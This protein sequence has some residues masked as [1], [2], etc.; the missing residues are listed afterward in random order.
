ME[1]TTTRQSRAEKPLERNR[2][3][4][5]GTAPLATM[6][7]HGPD[8]GRHRIAYAIAVA[9]QPRSSFTNDEVAELARR[10]SMVRVGLKP[11]GH[12]GSWTTGPRATSPRLWLHVMR[13]SIHQPVTLL[14]A[15][16]RLVRPA[17]RRPRHVL[18]ALRAAVAACYLA[19]AV[20]V[21]LVHCQ[22]GG[23]AAAGAYV[24]HRL[25]GVPY[26]VR[27][28]AYD[29]YDAYSWAGTVFSA[30]AGVI[31][32]SDHG[33]KS[34]KDRWGV[35][36]QVIRV[37]IPFGSITVRP[38]RMPRE[39]P[40]L[41]S[42]GSLVA[43]KGHDL[44]I[45]AV[46]LLS[47]SGTYLEL[48]IVGAGSQAAQLKNRAA[49]VD[50]VRLRGARPNEEVRSAYQGYDLFVMGSRVAPSGDRDGIP[51]VLMEA[52]AAKLPIVAT[53]V[54]GIPEL[55]RAGVSGSL[56]EPTAASL[57][58]AIRAA[59]NNYSHSLAM[60]DAA[61]DMVVHMHSLTGTVQELRDAWDHILGIR[62]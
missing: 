3:S 58:E 14:N 44:V 39:Q 9:P 30:S 10:T 54:G 48:D 52:A 55:I 42:V 60:A 37:G 4:L 33:A 19:D 16:W 7:S 1:S 11:R 61:F 2:A 28:H 35:D 32:I 62:T 56:A 57:A 36:A 13:R 38:R 15:M 5:S 45:A 21:D 23:P 50:G 6:P 20:D 34:I 46:E 29:I 22:F 17:W 18:V 12:A 8:E 49:M 53:A 59:L 47:Q 24:W 31:A 25:T 41:L 40:R 27:A 43:K 26:T 51:V